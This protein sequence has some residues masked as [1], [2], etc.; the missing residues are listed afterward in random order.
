V[1]S[2][3]CRRKRTWVGRARNLCRSRCDHVDIVFRHKV[4]TTSGIRPPSWSFW[5]KEASGEIGI[6]SSEKLGPQN[7]GIATEIASISVS[8]AELL[9]L[10]V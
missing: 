6:Y 9:V 2:M 3:Q 7:I 1:I 10:P 4:I 8:V 5:V